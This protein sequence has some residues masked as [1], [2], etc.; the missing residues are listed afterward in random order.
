MCRLIF[1]LVLFGAK[2]VEKLLFRVKVFLTC[3]SETFQSEFYLP[4]VVF[5]IYN[6]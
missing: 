3:N 5:Q 4:H 6:I 1:Y 2:Q